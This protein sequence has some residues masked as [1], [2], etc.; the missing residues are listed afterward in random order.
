MHARL[1]AAGVDCLTASQRAARAAAV[2][3]QLSALNI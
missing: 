3:S 2:E 1:H